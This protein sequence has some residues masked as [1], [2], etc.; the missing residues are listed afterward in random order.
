MTPILFVLFIFILYSEELLSTIL[1]TRHKARLE[2]EALGKRSSHGGSSS[3]AST[4][5]TVILTQPLRER[6]SPVEQSVKTTKPSIAPTTNYSSP[7]NPIAPKQEAESPQR[8]IS[9]Q[10]SHGS[11]PPTPQ[12]NTLFSIDSSPRTDILLSNLQLQTRNLNAKTRSTSIRFLKLKARVVGFEPPRIVDFSTAVCTNCS[13][14]YPPISEQTP[15]KCNR[16]ERGGPKFEYKFMLILEDE[17]LQAYNVHVD[18]D[19]M[20]SLVGAT[21]AQAKNLS[22]NTEA[23]EK[24]KVK[25]NRIGVVERDPSTAL[26]Q[27]DTPYFDCFIQMSKVNSIPPSDHSF[28]SPGRCYVDDGDSEAQVSSQPSEFMSQKRRAVQNEVRQGKRPHYDVSGDESQG[29]RLLGLEKEEQAEFRA[30]LVYTKIK[31]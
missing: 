24:L 4:S 5:G 11:P 6:P 10:V 12:F 3:C 23:L 31:M 21:D 7:S 25:L 19:S 20:R 30:S 16:C 13:N 22:K 26:V 27:E 29:L 18:D 15:K 8:P 14:P 9:R 28:N 1:Y 2:Y 17:L